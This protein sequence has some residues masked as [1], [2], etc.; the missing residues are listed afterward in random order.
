MLISRPKLRILK[1]SVIIHDQDPTDARNTVIVVRGLVP[2]GA[3]MLVSLYFYTYQ[4]LVKGA[5]LCLNPYFFGWLE[6]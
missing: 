4:G 1:N 3:A 5:K 2:G 6:K